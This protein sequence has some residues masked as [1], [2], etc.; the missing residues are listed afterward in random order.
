MTQPISNRAR[1][2]DTDLSC[3]ESSSE[4]SETLTCEEPPDSSCAPERA[5]QVEPIALH[6]DAGAGDA[7][8]VAAHG[9][10]DVPHGVAMRR[11]S[12]FCDRAD[13]VVEGFLCNDPLVVSNACRKPNNDFDEFVCD[14]P[15]MQRL[16]WAILRETWTLVKAIALALVRPKP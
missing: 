2:A 4:L 15:R 12:D 16:Q 11:A 13:T 7:P 14:D 5:H 10:A 8:R 1:W 9:D 6:R 3:S